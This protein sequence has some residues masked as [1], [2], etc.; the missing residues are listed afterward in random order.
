MVQVKFDGNQLRLEY[1]DTRVQHICIYSIIH[2][3]RIRVFGV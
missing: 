3:M 1:T 2:Y